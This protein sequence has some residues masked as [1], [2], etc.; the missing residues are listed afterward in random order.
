MKKIQNTYK[1]CIYNVN[2]SCCAF[3][4]YRVLLCAFISS[5]TVQPQ[6]KHIS[7]IYLQIKQLLLFILIT[8]LY[9]LPLLNQNTDNIDNDTCF[10]C[11]LVVVVVVVVVVVSG[12]G[13]LLLFVPWSLY[14]KILQIWNLVTV[15]CCLT[16][17]T[18]QGQNISDLWWSWGSKNSSVFTNDKLIKHGRKSAA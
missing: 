11:W 4:F 15:D 7:G 10:C 16:N 6:L 3:L 9:L 17:P 1:E 13:W 2:S 14:D 12:V 18:S 8:L 5:T